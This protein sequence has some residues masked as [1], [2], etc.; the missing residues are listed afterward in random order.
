LYEGQ[1]LSAGDDYFPAIC[2]ASHVLGSVILRIQEI[3]PLPGYEPLVGTWLWAFEN[4]H[5]RIFRTLEGLEPS[6][7]DRSPPWG[8]N[9]ISALLYHLAAIEV[10]WLFTDILEK[11][12]FPP[13]IDELFPDDV[14]DQDGNLTNI[15]GISLPAHLHRLTS[16]R[17]YSMDAVLDITDDE[18]RRIRSFP[19]YQ[20]TPQWVI[21]NLMQHGAEHRGQNM[22]IRETLSELWVTVIQLKYILCIP[23]VHL[24]NYINQAIRSQLRGCLLILHSNQPLIL[25]LNCYR[26]AVAIWIIRVVIT[27]TIYPSWSCHIRHC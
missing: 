2:G 3:K 5:Q 19:D 13:Q 14:R 4:S 12:K 9:T 15:P 16:V 10:D 18:F 24:I 27:E 6:L 11:D 26:C 1:F 21:Y 7:S 25:W 22:A 17:K 20:V 8:G 23:V